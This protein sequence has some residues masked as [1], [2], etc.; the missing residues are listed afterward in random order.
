MREVLHG[1]LV[2]QVGKALRE[3]GARQAFG[4]LDAAGQ[5]AL[6]EDLRVLMHERNRSDDHTL[7]LPSEYLE[8]VIE[9]G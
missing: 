6:T 7:V 1:R 4:A 9:R 5:A 3:R 8:V 2:E